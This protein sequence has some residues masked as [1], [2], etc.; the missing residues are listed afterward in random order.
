ML[1][2]TCRKRARNFI[3][4]NTAIVFV[5]VLYLALDSYFCIS[6]ALVFCVHA[7]HH[8]MHSRISSTT[9]FLARSH[10]FIRSHFSHTCI[11]RKITL[12]ARSNFAHACISSARILQGYK[13]FHP[14]AKLKSYKLPKN[15]VFST[16]PILVISYLSR[17]RA[18]A[19]FAYLA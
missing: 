15:T 4:I 2:H 8:F 11:F 3:A 5:I 18:I 14:A 1:S 19:F 13:Y 17:S 10:F 6:R 12:L 9:P 7:F 16:V